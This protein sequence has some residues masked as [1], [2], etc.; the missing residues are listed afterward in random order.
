MRTSR[1]VIFSASALALMVSGQSV[2]AQF[3]KDPSLES[4]LIEK[5]FTQLERIANAR[6]ASNPDDVQAILATGVIALRGGNSAQDVQKRKASIARAQACQLKQP[7]VAVCHYLVGSVLGVQ[8]MS[9]G[10]IKAATSASKIKEA[11]S[12]AVAL[13][14]QWYPARSAL[15]TFYMVAPGI[16]G[17]SESKARELARAAPNV[18]QAQALE[19]F[20]LLSSEKYEAALQTLGAIGP[21]IDL[22][23]N[24][25]IANWY[26]GAGMSLVS[27]GKFELARPAFESLVRNRPQDPNGVWGLA[28]IDAQTGNHAQ[29]IK[30]FNS[31]IGMSGAEFLP[32]DYRLGI[33][34]Q[35][36]GQKELAKAA[37]SKFLEA[38]QFGK[39]ALD[40]A[41][42]RLEKLDK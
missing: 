9:E 6:L 15:V 22:N 26:F 12:R 5:N 11:L 28:R 41:K 35:A 23:L 40:D 31:I 4:L 18:Q 13:D 30:Q 32:V 19:G 10:M 1:A 14:G 27:E 33:S 29:A 3:F 17:G 34:L 8:A 36:L 42:S 2:R 7:S 38:N 24:D 21:T 25:E 20:V 39:K 16:A 37:L